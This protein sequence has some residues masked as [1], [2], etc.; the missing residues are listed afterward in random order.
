MISV[1]RA[2]ARGE[3]TLI[4]ATNVTAIADTGAQV[5]VWSLGKFLQYGFSRDIL[6]PAP[7]LVAANHSCHQFR[8]RSSPFFAI[9]F[10]A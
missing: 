9:V 2:Q 1:D 7:N 6:T 5:N 10:Y 4:S 8:V 3:S